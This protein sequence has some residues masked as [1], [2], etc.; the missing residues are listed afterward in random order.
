MKTAKTILFLTLFCCITTVVNAQ[1]TVD[2]TENATKLVDILKGSSSCI[3]IS[4]PPTVKGDPTIPTNNSYGSFIGIGK[5]FPFDGIVLS[6]GSAKNSIGPFIKNPGVVTPGWGGDPD[7]KVALIVDYPANSPI[8][9]SSL[10]FDFTP[11]TNFIS[12]DYIFASNEY[13]D[14]YACRFSDGF[15]FLIKDIT[16]GFSSTYKNLAVIPGTTTP[17]SVFTVHPEIIFANSSGYPVGCPQKNQT[18]FGQSNT[19]VGNT[20]AINY[21]GQT[22]KMT[23][24]SVVIPNHTYHIKLVIADDASDTYDSAVFLEAGSFSSKIILT[25][26]KSNP[27][28]FGDSLDINTVVTG[29]NYNWYNLDV[30][31]TT[32]IG[33]NS[34]L[35]VIDAGTY[36]LEVDLGGG[37]FATGEIKVEFTPEIKKN[38]PT[39]T[40]CDDHGDGTATFDLT[41]AKT[42][43]L[44]GNPTKTKIEFFET[45]TGSIL[46]DPILYPSSF[47]KTGLP[48]K[49]V[50]AK[51]TGDYS[52]TAIAEIKLKTIPSTLNLASAP[53]P[54]I[55]EFS[56]GGNSVTLVP[57]TSSGNYQF[58]L[59][60]TNYQNSPLFINLIAGDYTGY[61]RDSSTCEYSTNPFV[62]LDYPNFFT[63]NEDGF[64]DEWEIK[65]LHTSYPKAIISI[66][67]RYGKLLKQITSGGG[68]WKGTFNGL[69]LPTDDY[70]F[71]IDLK[72]GEIVK[73][74]F[75]LK[76]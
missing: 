19:T 65:K 30:S 42:E 9:A 64:N 32:V 35:S 40:K 12:F 63:P 50:Y 34:S 5:G 51:L 10:E 52:C 54:I 56:G 58:S 2:D 62:I 55:N 7:L 45:Q 47:K 61:I 73:G 25:T 43:L 4:G 22:V 48:D 17:V 21:A 71:T 41:E 24:Q 6:T 72:N 33:T 26:S 76:R 59:D 39:L 69:K 31:A 11:L 70:W 29:S 38:N 75:S 1:I 37:C 57:P 49:T 20:S 3:T 60:E 36:K 13:Q 27:V 14:N 74:H 15:A 67:D 44:T 8:N 16:P 68:N 66:F 18:Y 28:C 46:S 23:A 53:P